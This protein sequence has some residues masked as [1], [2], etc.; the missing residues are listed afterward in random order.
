MPLLQG[1]STD[2]DKIDAIHVYT[3]LGIRF[4]NPVF[5]RQIKRD[6]QVF[7]YSVSRPKAIVYAQKTWSGNYAFHKLP[8]LSVFNPPDEVSPP[9]TRP[10]VI[11]VIDPSG[12]Y[13]SIATTITAPHKGLAMVG[14]ALTSPASTLKGL[15]LYVAANQ[16]VPRWNASI[17]GRLLD[18]VTNLPAKYAVVRVQVV[19]GSSF[20]GLADANGNF[21]V[22]M[23]FP[24]TH[25]PYHSSPA[26][27]GGVD[28]LQQR[29]DITL[30]VLYQP[31]HVDYYDEV[32]LPDY[33][34][35]LSQAKAAVRSKLNEAHSSSLVTELIYHQELIVKT[36]NDSEGRLL[37]RTIA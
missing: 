24:T 1:S 34:N 10:Y 4:W 33:W 37:V 18:E 20:Y 22:S 32:G 16:V 12:Y 6:L 2:P 25:Q 13:S 7:A 8:G 28:L 26:T 23:P 11:V 30:D 9:E 36:E 3:P 29:W 19:G 14:L 17:R 31:E 5:D 27:S 35:V 15:Y 21:L